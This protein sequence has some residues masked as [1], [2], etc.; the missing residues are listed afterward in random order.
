MQKIFNPIINLIKLY[1]YIDLAFKCYTYTD[2][3]LE[4]NH[5]DKQS[6]ENAG[7]G[8]VFS[9]GDDKMAPGCGSCWC[10]QPL[11]INLY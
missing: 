8:F 9:K 11:G 7:V 10:C 3:G 5:L 4:K 1:L 2:A 6:C